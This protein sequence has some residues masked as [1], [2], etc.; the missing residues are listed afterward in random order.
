MEASKRLREAHAPPTSIS[1]QSTYQT[2]PLPQTNNDGCSRQGERA[3]PRRR[4]LDIDLL[5][6]RRTSPTTAAANL[7]IF[8]GF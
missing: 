8:F 5:G 6:V 1:A 2:L 3:T 7:V 4:P